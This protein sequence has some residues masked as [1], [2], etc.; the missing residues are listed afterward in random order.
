MKKQKPIPVPKGKF[1]VKYSDGTTAV[2]TCDEANALQKSK[3]ERRTYTVYNDRGQA[4]F[5]KA[6]KG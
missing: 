4:A 5:T 6:Y 1:L 2:M 3:K